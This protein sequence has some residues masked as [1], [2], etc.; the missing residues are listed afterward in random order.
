MPEQSHSCVN[1]LNCLRSVCWPSGWFHDVIQVRKCRLMS[2]G[3]EGALRNLSSSRYLWH[4]ARAEL[5]SL[6]C[7]QTLHISWGI[8]IRDERQLLVFHVPLFPVSHPLEA[9][10]NHFG[11]SQR[12]EDLVCECLQ[13]GKHLLNRHCQWWKPQEA[14]VSHEWSCK[15]MGTHRLQQSCTSKA[16]FHSFVVSIPVQGQGLQAPLNVICRQAA[17]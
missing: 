3:C 1:I 6:V 7:G 9:V 16:L 5:V 17:Q 2:L 10:F 11:L 14:N 13:L 15:W 12:L 8:P 4:C